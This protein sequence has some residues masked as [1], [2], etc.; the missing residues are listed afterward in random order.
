MIDVGSVEATREGKSNEFVSVQQLERNA[1]IEL[2]KEQP[3]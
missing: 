1:L 2:K 3:N